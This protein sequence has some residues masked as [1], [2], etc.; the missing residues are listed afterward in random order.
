MMGS[1]AVSTTASTIA[2]S[3]TASGASG[4]IFSHTDPVEVS[5]AISSAISST[6]SSEMVVSISSPDGVISGSLVAATLR[7]LGAFSVR[8]VADGLGTGRSAA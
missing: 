4:T 2:D 6:D 1:T 5:S 3:C 7:A 8:E